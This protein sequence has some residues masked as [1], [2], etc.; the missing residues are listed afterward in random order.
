MLG[1]LGPPIGAFHPFFFHRRAPVVSV[2]VPHA[3][4]YAG[5]AA[6]L[7]FTFG[8]LVIDLSSIIA[9]ARSSA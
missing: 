7:G 1:F 9:C 4:D 3:W 2:F 6:L 8:A 5:Q